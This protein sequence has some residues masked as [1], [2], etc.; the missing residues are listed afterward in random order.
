MAK[1]RER[2]VFT[3]TEE[4]QHVK[5]SPRRER[6]SLMTDLMPAQ[7]ERLSPYKNQ[8]NQFIDFQ[9][10]TKKKEKPRFFLLFINQNLSPKGEVLPGL[11]P[12]CYTGLVISQQ[13]ALAQ[14]RTHTVIFTKPHNANHIVV[15]KARQRIT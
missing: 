10:L 3:A 4:T 14:L 12:R 1:R 9:P 8:E 2:Q 11:R 13:C 15:S 7:N 6:L 5:T